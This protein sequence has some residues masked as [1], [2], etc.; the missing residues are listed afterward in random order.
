VLLRFAEIEEAKA[1]E[2]ERQVNPD[3]SRSNS[4]LLA[5]PMTVPAAFLPFKQEKVDAGHQRQFQTV[6]SL[7]IYA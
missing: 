4:M 3:T 1:R 5:S 7:I 6:N 2:A